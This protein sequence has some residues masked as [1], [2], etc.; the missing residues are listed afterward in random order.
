MTEPPLQL[1]A[2]L[3]YAARG[4]AVVPSHFP[5]PADR[6]G[7]QR[8]QGAFA[9]SCGRADCP[10]PARHPIWTTSVEDATLDA[11]SL[12]QWW[13]G[14]P[15]ANVATPAG[16]SFDLIEVCHPAPASQ[17]ACWLRKQGIGAGPLIGAG[18]THHQFLVAAGA[19]GWSHA[20]T[21]HGGL[22]RLGRSGGLILLP[23]SR[24]GDG[25]ACRWLRPIGAAPLPDGARVYEALAG[26]PGAGELAVSV[27][28][29]LQELP[30]GRSPA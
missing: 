3:E 28:D 25:A 19:Q 24:L 13:V 20:V 21:E 15:D 22:M 30:S 10:T 17:I 11:V 26:L 23:P 5:V 7:P 18:P 4:I 16:A 27:G 9:C 6:A 2:A 12:A 1:Q 29:P 14:M 8:P